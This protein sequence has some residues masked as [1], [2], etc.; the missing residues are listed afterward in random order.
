MGVQVF[1]IKPTLAEILEVG[2]P[3]GSMALGVPTATSDYDVYMTA[4]AYYKL[5]KHSISQCLDAMD[6]AA[7]T[8]IQPRNGYCKIRYKF[9]T[10]DNHFCDI[11]VLEYDSDLA[12]IEFAMND[13][14]AIPKYLMKDKPFRIAAFQNALLHYGFKAQ[15]NVEKQS[16]NVYELKIYPIKPASINHIKHIHSVHYHTPVNIVGI[17][18]YS[19]FGRPITA[20]DIGHKSNAS[21]SILMNPITKFLN[22]TINLTKFIDKN[23]ADLLSQEQYEQLFKNVDKSLDIEP[24]PVLLAE[25]EEDF[26]AIPF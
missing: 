24:V 7:Y 4:D 11:L 12:I 14:A 23:K 18:L 2:V 25:Q 15:P 10:A 17:A 9:K 16:P 3:I 26:T 21:L 8:A 19:Y 22:T 13:L 20:E 6:S 5:F 1:D